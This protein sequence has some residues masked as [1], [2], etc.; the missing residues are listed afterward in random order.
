MESN[1]I[2]TKEKSNLEMILTYI[3][4]DSFSVGSLQFNI[5]EECWRQ[6]KCR[7]SPCYQLIIV[8]MEIAI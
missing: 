1:I 7:T 6:G 8:N 3:R 2:L 4:L 5:V